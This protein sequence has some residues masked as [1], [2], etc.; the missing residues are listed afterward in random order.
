MWSN[1]SKYSTEW[2]F[3][4][5]SSNT[6]NNIPFPV[7]YEKKEAIHSKESKSK[8]RNQ[9]VDNLMIASSCISTHHKHS[10]HCFS[11]AENY[12]NNFNL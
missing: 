8:V 5:F 10:S 11:L 6:M 7:H 12:S 3:M 9:S 2:D 1:M 4:K